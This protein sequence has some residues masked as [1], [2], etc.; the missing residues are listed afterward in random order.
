MSCDSEEYPIRPFLLMKVDAMRHFFINN[1][2]VITCIFILFIHLLLSLNG[3]GTINLDYRYHNI[4]Y[5]YM[6]DNLIEGLLYNHGQPPG[7]LLVMYIFDSISGG[8]KDHVF[9]FIYP[10]LHCL[11]FIF[12]SQAVTRLKIRKTTA[13]A[14]SLVLFLNPLIFVYYKY[15]DYTGLIFFISC[16][17]IYILFSSFNVNYKTILVVLLI[18]FCCL[19]RPS[20]HVVILI[21]LSIYLLF[22]YRI[23]LRTVLI[24][25]IIIVIP[26][27]VY[28]KNYL[29]FGQPFSSSW[30]GINLSKHIPPSKINTQFR[31]NIRTGNGVTI[32]EYE[33]ENQTYTRLRKKS[34][35]LRNNDMNDIKVIDISNG[36]MQNLISNFSILFSIKVIGF[37]LLRF[38]DSPATF[39]WLYT[40]DTNPYVKNNKLVHDRLFPDIFDIPNFFKLYSQEID[41]QYD[42]PISLYLFVYPFVIA[43]IAIRYIKY[44]FEIRFIFILTCLLS[45][46]YVTI[47]PQEA[48]RFRFEIEPFYYFL[49]IY[50]IS[51]ILNNASP[52]GLIGSNKGA[53]H[54]PCFP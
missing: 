24:S 1:F 39:S 9:S 33:L 49:S 44:E 45:S 8:N 5:V 26:L 46:I 28:T 32:K 16:A 19:M 34:A 23:R 52:I 17:I 41:R 48:M 40:R 31:D 2:Y 38:F 22:H 12:F 14:L 25:A 35:F 54:D 30:L 51:K 20:W 11:C 27:L 3:F 15:P 4:G 36:L 42:I 6:K 21:L 18:G 43:F 10:I 47:D 37:G 50:S 13:K 29:I 7:F 53:R